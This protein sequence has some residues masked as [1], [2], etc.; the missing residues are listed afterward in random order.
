[1]KQD[2]LTNI[3]QDLIRLSD[4]NV[5]KTTQRYFKEQ[6]KVYGVST[7]DVRKIGERYFN[8][9][10]QSGKIEIFSL[11]EELLKSD[12][13]EEA[14]IAFDWTY[15]LRKEYESGDF[16]IFE[17][18]LK[19]YVNNWA[20]CDI[21]CNHTFGAFIEKYPNYAEKLKQRA[22]SRN[23]W[24]RRA[25]AVSLIIP[26]KKGQFLSDILQIADI[27]LQDKDDLVQKGCG[28]MLKAA[29]Q[30]HLQE[31]FD[32]IMRNKKVMPRTTLR[33]A[34]EKMPDELKHKAMSKN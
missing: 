16:A 28:W 10:S 8:S 21:L 29:S 17:R 34:I 22:K 20:K 11:C 2:I 26:A 13:M 3:R 23:R 12:Y 5:G 15:R 18:W 4:P 32:Y 9:I 14:I 7:P 25:S 33:Y 19:K 31:V 27:L 24:L 6:V 30:A 1:M